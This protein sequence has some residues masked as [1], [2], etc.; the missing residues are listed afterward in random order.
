[1]TRNRKS[2]IGGEAA[3][4]FLGSS[5]LQLLLFGGKGGVGK[6]TCATAAALRL[7]ALFPGRS[8]LLVSSDP[9]HS[10]QDSLAGAH[11]PLN[12]CV[13]E[14]DAQA[15]LT[16]FRAEHGPK[17]QRIAAAG[18]F[19]D[20]EDIQKFLSL[21]LPGL[22]ELMA[23]LQISD[24]VEHR[25]HDC[26]VVDTA[27]SGHSLRLLAMPALLRKWLSVLD[28]LLAKTRYMRKVFSRSSAPDDLD[29][30][31]KDWWASVQRMAR[32]LRDPARCRFVPVTI[33]ERLSVR[34]TATLLQE[35]RRARVSVSEV[36]I[37][38]L[39]HSGACA[40]C[41][42]AHT[43]EE[44]EMRWL[45]DAV[46]PLPLW[47]VESFP[48]EVRGADPLSAFWAHTRLHATFSADA[49][50][51][52]PARR[53]AA[54][55]AAVL[56]A[57]GVQLILF[58]GKGGVGKTTLACST[59][60]RLATNFADK[61]ILLFSTDP[62]HSLAACLDREVGPR[63]VPVCPGLCVMEIDSR[64]E[65][66]ALKARYAGDIR[67][68]FQSMSAS[69]DP[70]FDRV[71]LERIMDL[72]PP[73]L[74]EVMALVRIV[75][76]LSRDRYDLLVL[77]PAATGHFLRLVE[78][79]ALIDQWLKT[80]FDFLLKYESIFTLPGFSEQLVR[81]SKRL[82]QF[83]R[84][85]ADPGQSLVYA[86]SI[87]TEMAWEET[88]DLLEACARMG[89]HVPAI[90]LN[91]MTPPADCAWCAAARRREDSVVTRFR[92]AF[93]GQRQVLLYRQEQPIGLER[94]SRLGGELFQATEKWEAI[95]A[96]T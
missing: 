84:L 79:P 38:Q 54:A 48:E 93:P 60:L 55:T 80:M 18:T 61:R 19:L 1:M 23:F 88:K 8:F 13:L 39:H 9:A 83:R 49:A 17:L 81:F 91:L 7:A 51:P 85:L 94:L 76:L 42:Q 74:D 56:P 86:V 16:A 96:R 28:A 66:E 36:V 95:E 50:P 57:S 59:A 12:L 40:A 15:C 89:L 47:T 11:L 21:S 87:P 46:A 71:V 68:F 92:E 24:W 22:D 37:N 26:I 73:G 4:S 27:P 64:A 41:N 62:A 52:P 53:P 2:D 30:F 6:T 29:L 63:P 43:R 75:D 69:L 77:D 44:Q 67:D 82:K 35:L 65:F 90:F 78:L 33:A 14:L 70:T 34:E 25:C 31:L 3:P 72:A 5:D 32:L 10:L 58:A 45:A 20:D